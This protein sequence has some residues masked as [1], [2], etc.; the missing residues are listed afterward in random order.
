LFVA[1]CV[2]FNSI[3]GT[4]SCLNLNHVHGCVHQE[5]HSEVSAVNIHNLC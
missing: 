4:F 2:V 3:I 1:Q 5:I